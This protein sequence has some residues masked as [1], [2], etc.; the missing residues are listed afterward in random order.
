MQAARTELAPAAAGS[1][2]S[3]RSEWHTLALHGVGATKL[4]DINRAALISQ[5]D[6]EWIMLQCELHVGSQGWHQ[7]LQHK[8]APTTDVEV[9]KWV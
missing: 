4:D 5:H 6:C 8:A 7:S 2:W 1:A 9:S 3:C